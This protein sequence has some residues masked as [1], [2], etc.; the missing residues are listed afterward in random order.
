MTNYP[1]MYN[2]GMDQLNLFIG[3]ALGKKSEETV[4]WSPLNK[5]NYAIFPIH[6]KW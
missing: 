4:K 1:V 6:L 2:T 5:N 3:A